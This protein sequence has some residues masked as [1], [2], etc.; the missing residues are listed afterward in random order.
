VN[1][2]T[3]AIRRLRDAL[4]SRSIP[5]ATHPNEAMESG[6]AILRRVEPFAET[7]FLVMVADEQAAAAE[8]QALHAAIG[9]LTDSAI[10]PTGIQEM[11][12]GFH[13]RLSTSSAESRLAHIGASFGADREDREI[14]FTLAAAMALADDQVALVEN[15]ILAWVREYF[16]ISDQRVAALIES[17]D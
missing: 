8:H 7:M 3:A 2:N 11:I 10:G 17:I 14:A 4:L 1:V 13:A 9:I 15:R 5:A 16:G 6:Q 12:D